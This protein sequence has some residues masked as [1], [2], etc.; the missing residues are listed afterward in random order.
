MNEDQINKI[1]TEL[2]GWLGPGLKWADNGYYALDS[3]RNVVGGYPIFTQDLN[4]ANKAELRLITAKQWNNYVVALAKVIA[5]AKSHEKVSVPTNV[6]ITAS[7]LERCKAILVV[8]KKL[9]L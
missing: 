7:A 8:L 9:T 4:Y 6:L 2:L 5:K 3:M 1:I